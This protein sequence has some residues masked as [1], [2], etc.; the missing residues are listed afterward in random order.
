LCHLV[1]VARAIF[2]SKVSNRLRLK[3]S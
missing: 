2:K 3:M 1:K